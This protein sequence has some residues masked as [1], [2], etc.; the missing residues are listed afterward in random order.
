MS[1]LEDLGNRL[2]DESVG[3]LW[4]D[5]FLGRRPDTPDQCVTLQT[6]PG[7]A[8]RLRS[9]NNVPVDERFNVQVMT[10]AARDG[11]KSAE[12]LAW[13]AFD[14]IQSRSATLDSSR[15]YA[16]IRAVQTPAYIGVDA[17]NRPLVSFNVEVRRHRDS[18]P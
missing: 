15:R 14:A 13:S 6:Y 2:E 3:T 18:L 8:S 17:N 4:T 10:R 9:P 16:H 7:D 11:Q 5:L 1:V 12:T